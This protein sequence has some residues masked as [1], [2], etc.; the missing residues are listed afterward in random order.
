MDYIIEVTAGNVLLE[1]IEE[2]GE[3]I[4]PSGLVLT[5]QAQK[6]VYYKVLKFKNSAE[7][8][9]SF[10]IGDLVEIVSNQNIKRLPAEFGKLAITSISAVVA[11]YRKK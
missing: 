4:R 10:E 1:V 5:Q 6:P 3:T 9:A 8:T 7:Y 11:Y 2:S